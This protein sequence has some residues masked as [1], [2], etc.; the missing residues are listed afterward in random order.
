[1]SNIR[2]YEDREQLSRAA[3]E[4]F[5][6]LAGRGRDRFA[7]ALAGGSTPKGLYSLLASEQYSGR[8]EWEN[9]LFLVGDERDVPADSP[10]SNFRMASET[11]FRPLNVPDS[12][13]TRWRTELDNP[14][15]TAE[16]FEMSLRNAFPS[17]AETG[18]IPRI[19]LV[20][21][22]LG[23]DAHT[24]SLFPYT[25]ALSETE[26]LAVENRVETLDAWRFTITFPLINNAKNVVFLAAGRDKAEAVRQVIEGG[27]NPE[28]YPAQG[29]R[30]RSG[31]LIWLLD[32]DAA[33]LLQGR[34]S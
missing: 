4:L 31:R 30:P 26:R 14:E 21:L 27:R 17:A 29:V 10:E 15:M 33:A 34:H 6:E 19:D 25:D 1:M 12:H 8:I 32:A 7:F 16:A 2:I 13:I 28:K 24:A 9:L 22:G 5:V 11:L 3:A 23:N 18:A 20:L